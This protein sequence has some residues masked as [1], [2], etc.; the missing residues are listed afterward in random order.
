MA[1]S[2]ETLVLA[3]KYADAVAAAGSKEALEKAV[4]E[5]VTQSEKYTD[6]Q[7]RVIAE[8]VIVES[9]IPLTEDEINHAFSTV[10][11]E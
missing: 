2:V 9:V 6:T 3:K 7:S 11:L 5:A 4:Q 10:T 8:E 1:I